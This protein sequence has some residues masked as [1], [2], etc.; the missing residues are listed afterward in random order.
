VSDWPPGSFEHGLTGGHP[1]SLGNTLAIVETVF[2]DPSR[3]DELLGCYRSTNEVVRL[4]TSNGVKR[5]CR[6]H[7]EWLVPFIDRLIDEVGAIDQA[8]AQW[9]LAD[10]FGMLRPR[11]SEDQAGRAQSLMQRN[12]VRSHDWIV[13]NQTLE[14]LATW[15]LDDDALKAWLR[16]HL[17]R[18]AGDSRK[19]V[20]GRALKVRKR[21]SGP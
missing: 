3:L 19:S 2:A 18:L 21:L 4:R 5:V 20:A 11:M 1:N 7:P 8:S 15:A 6:A 17:D 12:L 9:T 14:T 16:P 13:L 10:L